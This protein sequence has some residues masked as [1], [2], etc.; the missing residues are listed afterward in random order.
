[1]TERKSFLTFHQVKVE[2]EKIENEVAH[3]VYAVRNQSYK[4]FWV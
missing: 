3:G 4:T 2:Y 1:M